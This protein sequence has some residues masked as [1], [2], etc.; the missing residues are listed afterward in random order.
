MDMAITKKTS[1]ATPFRV[2]L[3]VH[4]NLYGTYVSHTHLFEIEPPLFKKIQAWIMGA[5][6]FNTAKNLNPVLYTIIGTALRH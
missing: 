2:A 5:A 3:A 1:S 6:K 4:M